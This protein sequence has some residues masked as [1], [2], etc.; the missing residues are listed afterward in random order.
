MEKNESHRLVKFGIH[1]PRFSAALSLNDDWGDIRCCIAKVKTIESGT[2]HSFSGFG[3]AFPQH[4]AKGE[5]GMAG[6]GVAGGEL[7]LL[8]DHFHFEVI[9]QRFA[10]LF[11]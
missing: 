3:G 2:R 11:I 7:I 10:E 6:H 5:A 9:F 8:F 4:C 1:I